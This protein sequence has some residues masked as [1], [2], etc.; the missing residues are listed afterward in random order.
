MIGLSVVY[1]VGPSWTDAKW[2]WV[3]WGSALAAILLV[4]ASMIFTWYIAEFNSYDRIYGSLGAAVGFMT[5]IWLSVVVVLLGA[6]LDAAIES[7]R[8][9]KPLSN[10]SAPLRVQRA[11]SGEDN[12]R[13][14]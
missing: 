13:D 11:P 5:W 9:E 12:K 3:T 7:D 10:S 4:A 6:E 14:T 2:R 1:R 8:S